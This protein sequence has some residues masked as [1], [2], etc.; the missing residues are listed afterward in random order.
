M[1]SLVKERREKLGMSQADLVKKSGISRSTIH[2]IE[3]GGEINLKLDTMRAIA[4]A[5]N[6]QV[7]TIFK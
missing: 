2:V 5:L 4:K 7:G 6:C 3:E 1:G